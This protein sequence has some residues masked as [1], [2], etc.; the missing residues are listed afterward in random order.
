MA[1]IKIPELPVIKH[2]SNFF[3]DG[4]LSMIVIGKSG[5]GKTR[6]LASILPGLSDAIQT[7]LVASII[8][9]VPLHKAIVDYYRKKGIRTGTANS[10]E[11]IKVAVN[12]LEARGEVTLE[13]Q[14]LIIFDD[15]NNG[16]STGPYWDFVIHAFTKLRNS[17]WNFIIMAQQPSFLPP[18]VRTCSTCRVLFDCYSKSAFTTFAK[19]VMDRLPNRD[20]FRVLV[21]YLQEVPFSYILVQ[22]HPFEIGAGTLDKCKTV[23]NKNMV[24]MPSVEALEKELGV[25][26]L[27]E[28]DA[29][30]KALQIK[31]GNNN[32]NLTE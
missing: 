32:P 20:M 19:D 21:R 17:G 25:P 3:R 5:C 23:I 4:F 31:A 27:Q 6:F 30:T 9:D 16:K 15:F 8:K 7:V 18:I 13:K 2:K 1:E 14:G 10:P 29:K 11:E 22:E 28:L 26:N 24:K 12:V